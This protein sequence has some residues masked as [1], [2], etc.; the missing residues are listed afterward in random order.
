VIAAFSSS[1]ASSAAVGVGSVV[2]DILVESIFVVVNVDICKYPMQVG[3]VVAGL[4]CA[5]RSSL[6]LSRTRIK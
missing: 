6:V 4:S 5:W 3:I 2:A 1:K